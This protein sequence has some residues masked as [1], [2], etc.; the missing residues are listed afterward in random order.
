MD[1]RLSKAHTET[2]RRDGNDG[3]C[4]ADDEG[5]GQETVRRYWSIREAAAE[6]ENGTKMQRGRRQYATEGYGGPPERVHFVEGEP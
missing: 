6:A 5:R 2:E 1:Q 3:I 4:P